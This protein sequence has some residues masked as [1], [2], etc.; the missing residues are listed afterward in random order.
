MKY[1]GP[2][3]L[4]INNQFVPSVEGRTF[5]TIN[6]A[7]ETVI[8]ELWQGGPK[9]VEKA[10]AAAHNCFNNPDSKWRSFPKSKRRDL[11]LKLADLMQRDA[12]KLAVV[13]SADN[14]KPVGVAENVDVALAIK[15]FRYYAGWADK[16]QGKTIPID[17]DY[18]CYTLHEPV[19]VV[20]QIIPW[21][22][23]I[24]MAAWKLGPALATGCT[25]VMKSSEKTPLT[26]LMLCDLIREAGYPAG[27]V[28][29]LS[30][31]GPG[32]GEHIVNHPLVDKIAFTGSTATGRLIAASAGRNLKR[33][34]L[35]LGGKSP[36]IIFPD[37]NVDLAVH[38]AQIGIFLNSGQCCIAGSRV[39][40]HEDIYDEFIGK[41]AAA[42]RKQVSLIKHNPDGGSIFDLGPI[43]DNIQCNKVMGYVE[44]GKSEARLVCGGRRLNCKG[45]WVEPTIFADVTDDMKIAKEEIFGPVMSVLKF[46]CADEVIRRANNTPYGLGAGVVTNDIATAHRVSQKLRAGTVYVNCYDVF[47]AAAPFGGFKQSG[48]GRELGEYGL[49]AYTEVKTVIIPTSKM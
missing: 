14:G 29:M 48:I 40:V 19:G 38:V 15:C 28:N 3:G 6:P 16:L 22:F 26:A 4:F 32:C 21:N 5:K 1:D 41:A 20:G 46:K 42:A 8:A 12:H 37:A 47:D 35:E 39:F 31:Y 7:D 24:L 34:S 10:V 23:P 11:M 44:H 49:K 18:F 17:G 27:V 36:L 25:V 33:C 2:I 30:G 13:E 43:V 9:D 45:F